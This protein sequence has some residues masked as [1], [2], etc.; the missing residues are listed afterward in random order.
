[1][2]SLMQCSLQIYLRP[3]VS[4]KGSPQ[5]KYFLMWQW[6]SR[7][8]TNKIAQ[9]QQSGVN[10]AVLPSPL[11]RLSACSTCQNRGE[12]NWEKGTAH[13]CY[14]FFITACARHITVPSGNRGKQGLYSFLVRDVP[15]FKNTEGWPQNAEGQGQGG[16]RQR[17]ILSS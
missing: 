15:E 17:A 8:G 7:K 3:Q 11:P 12:I 6:P 16:Q 4:V 2:A 9:I 13:N 14:G 5:R 10:Y 1:M